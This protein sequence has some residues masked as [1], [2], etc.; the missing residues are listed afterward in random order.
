[1]LCIAGSSVANLLLTRATARHR[2]MAVRL[3]LGA[4][5][6]KLIRQM[7]LESSLL[8][9]GGGLFGVVV[10]LVGMRMLT[11]FHMP[12]AL[13]IDLNLSAD[14]RVMMYA[15]LLSAGTGLLC[16]LA[17]VFAGS[18]PAVPNALKGESTL[19]RP[20]RR[21]SLRNVLVVV[22]ISACLVLL[23]TT[24]LYLHSLAKLS[25]IDPGFRTNGIR[26]I[27]V[28]PVHNGYRAEQVPLLLKRMHDRVSAI[29]G[30][31]SAVWT[32]EVPLSMGCPANQFHVAGKAQIG[33]V[34]QRRTSIA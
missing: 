5:R 4:T 32:D 20:G 16:G 3:A 24:G 33:D 23:C 34:I 25:D 30:V 21:W 27:S 7:M 18:R 19:E 29:P 13:P 26:I 31:I 22:Q 12:I 2:E 1:M 17:P 14:W 9:L 11:A 6:G 15:F 28:D 8:A 10:S